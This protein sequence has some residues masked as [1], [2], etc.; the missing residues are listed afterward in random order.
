[1]KFSND[2]VFSTLSYF[3]ASSI[4]AVLARICYGINMDTGFIMSAVAL[5]M[6]MVAR[7]CLDSLK[8]VDELDRIQKEA[9]DKVTKPK[10]EEKK[11]KFLEK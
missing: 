11:Y 7:W 2:E 10:Q 9:T 6:G 5:F 4:C 1:M 8:I 3:V